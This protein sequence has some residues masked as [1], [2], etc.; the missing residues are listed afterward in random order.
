MKIYFIIFSATL[1]LTAGCT[2]ESRQNTRGMFGGERNGTDIHPISFLKVSDGIFVLD[3]AEKVL[4]YQTATK[5]IQG[6]F[7]RS[8]YV[9]PL[10]SLDG[11]ILT[12]DFPKDHMHHRGIFWAWHQILLSGEK[13]ADSWVMKDFK[14]DIREVDTFI[15]DKKRAGLHADVLWKSSQLTDQKGKP[16]PFVRENTTICVHVAEDDLRKIDFQIE[17]LALKPDV[18]IGG[19]EN[20][21]GYGGFTT[22]LILADDLEFVGRNGLVEPKVTQ[23]QAGPWLDFTGHFNENNISGITILAHETVPDYPSPWILRRKGSAQ[24]AVFPGRKTVQVGCDE[25]LVLRYRLIIHRGRLNIAQL[26]ELQKEYNCKKPLQM[27]P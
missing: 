17:L 2:P 19:A 12:E 26:E 21:K 22:R 18:R 20:V 8:N 7:P 11:E 24:N 16:E 4:F 1:M 5:D 25:P 15:L 6:L 23:V 14:F 27:S 9:H 13:I 10:Y 3:S